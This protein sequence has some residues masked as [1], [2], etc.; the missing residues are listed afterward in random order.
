MRGKMEH[1]ER[2]AEFVGTV[3]GAAT[4]SLS[5]WGNWIADRSYWRCNSSAFTT[6]HCYSTSLVHSSYTRRSAYR[7]T[8]S[9]SFSPMQQYLSCNVARHIKSMFKSIQDSPCAY[10]P[11]R[12]LVALVKKQYHTQM[13]LHSCKYKRSGLVLEHLMKECFEMM[14]TIS[15]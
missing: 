9:A 5:I 10:S 3:G 11:G 8:C 15:R 4:R 7:G 13:S 6:L 2:M 12:G 14:K 1:E